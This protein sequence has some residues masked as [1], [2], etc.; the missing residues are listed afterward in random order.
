MRK[1]NDL[2]NFSGQ[3]IQEYRMK[4]HMSRDDLAK[5]LQ[6]MGFCVDRTYIHKVEK[7]KVILK[8]FELI[9]IGKVLQIDYKDLEDLYNGTYNITT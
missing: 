2:P 8:D 9:A 6:L 3:I 7:N 1:F 4:N 5:K